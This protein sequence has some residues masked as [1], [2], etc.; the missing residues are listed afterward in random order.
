[1]RKL[2]AEFKALDLVVSINGDP[3][4]WYYHEQARKGF[5]RAIGR[6]V[7]YGMRTADL[8]PAQLHAFFFGKDDNTPAGSKEGT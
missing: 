8:T 2:E 4:E 3:D 5:E 6:L 7:P 1:M